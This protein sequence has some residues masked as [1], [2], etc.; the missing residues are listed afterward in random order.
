M[1]SRLT[2]R[3]VDAILTA[4]EQTLAGPID[5]SPEPD[6]EAAIVAALTSARE[7]LWR[8]QA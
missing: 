7:K 1:S 5:G 6:E 4:I 3:E 2:R 8:R